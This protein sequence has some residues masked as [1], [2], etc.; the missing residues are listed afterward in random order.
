MPSP[1][2]WKRP[3]CAL[4]AMAASPGHR[5]WV[6]SSLKM[7]VL[8]PGMLIFPFPTFRERIFKGDVLTKIKQAFD[9]ARVTKASQHQATT[10]K[11]KQASEM[12]QA[13]TT[14][15]TKL[16]RCLLGDLAIQQA[17]HQAP[18]KAPSK[19]RQGS[20]LLQA[21]KQPSQQASTKPCPQLMLESLDLSRTKPARHKKSAIGSSP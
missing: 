21:S 19:A 20:Y 18:S 7:L 11:T 2:R 12:D 4:G 14:T 6:K 17:R 15:K 8:A 10:T 16:G 9:W 3:S 5:K 13:T 1:G